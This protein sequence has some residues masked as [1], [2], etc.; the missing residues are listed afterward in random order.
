MFSKIIYGLLLWCILLLF[1]CS[2]KNIMSKYYYQHAEELDK[3]E[4]LYK[5]L[6]QRKPFTLGFTSKSF[7]NISLEII[8][9]SLT[10]I[11]D[12]DI[13]DTHLA[14]TL[15]KYQLNV[16]GT[17][18]LISLMKSI[19]CTWINN[20]DY[21]IDEQKHSLI[22]MS[23]KPVALNAPFSNKKYYILTYFSQKQYFDNNGRLLNNRGLKKLHRI[24]GEI[25]NRINDKVCYTIS[26]RFR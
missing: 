20:F 15:K 4:E 24:N 5:T 23:V 13:N 12:F 18:Q 8:T 11:Y 2:P 10:Y 6:Y 7:K 25:F 14:D 17:Y 22:F 19:R 21:Y 3:I 1:S 26:S 9:D 16:W